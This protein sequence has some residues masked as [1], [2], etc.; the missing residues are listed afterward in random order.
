MNFKD[1]PVTSQPV[2]TWLWNGKITEKEI[3][4]QIDEMYDSG[5]RA[6]D[7]LGEPEN[8]RPTLR[9]THLSPE[10]L[11]EEYFHLVRHAYVY[12]KKKGMYITKPDK[13][14]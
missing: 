12:A 2:Y 11:S 3:E 8:F 6:F 14:N 5:I 10:Y 7:I 9:R 4:R 1:I 13:V